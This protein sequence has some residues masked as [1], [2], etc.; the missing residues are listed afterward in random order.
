MAIWGN[1]AHIVAEG[2]SAALKNLF[3]NG[4]SESSTI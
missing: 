3:V 4:H 2:S 1:K